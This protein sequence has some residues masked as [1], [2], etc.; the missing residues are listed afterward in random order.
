MRKIIFIILIINLVGCKSVDNWH[1]EPVLSATTINLAIKYVND[2]KEYLELIEQRNSLE[3]QNNLSIKQLDEL[4]IIEKYI[5]L[6]ARKVV[7]SWFDFNL[8]LKQ[9]PSY[10]IA[11]KGHY[12][13]RKSIEALEYSQKMRKVTNIE[14]M[15]D[16]ICF[17]EI[18][19]I[20]GLCRLSI[21]ELVAN[22]TTSS[23]SDSYYK[24]LKK[25]YKSMD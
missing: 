9:D 14:T 7:S 3:I 2:Q 15:K 20:E 21:G 22:N 24:R 4:L 12:Y 25:L 23:D 13:F 10:H 11:F 19:N 8:G 6:S 5:A 1:S 18:K 17:E 16:N